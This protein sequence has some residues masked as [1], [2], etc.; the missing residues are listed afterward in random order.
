M[1]PP[2]PTPRGRSP[3][4]EEWL[5]LQPFL[6]AALALPRAEGRALL[7]AP[8]QGD[9]ELLIW[10]ERFLEGA[11]ED[12][13]PVSLPPA[14]IADALTH[15]ASPVPETRFGPYRVRREIGRGGMGAVFLAERVDGQFDQQVAIKVVHRG[16]DGID[17]R[18]GHERFM[19]ER[20]LLARLDH[21][22][23]PTSSTEG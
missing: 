8:C 11:S 14:L 10:M 12:P 1:P 3:T 5:R 19:R 22:N 23:M 9:P 6:D 17:G 20:Q 18:D 4:R 13:L 7:D 21:P 16:L 15:D 2:H